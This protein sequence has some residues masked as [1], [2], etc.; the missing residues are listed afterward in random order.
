M[1]HFIKLI[2]DTYNPNYPLSKDILRKVIIIMIKI[3]NNIKSMKTE[4]SS[5]ELPVASEI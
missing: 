4:K 3:K 5:N 1:N 2:K